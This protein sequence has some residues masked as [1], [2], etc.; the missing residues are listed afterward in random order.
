ML[1]RIKEA[2]WGTN[3][4]SWSH[5]FDREKKHDYLQEVSNHFH[6]LRDAIAKN[7]SSMIKF[8]DLSD[9]MIQVMADFYKNYFPKI[10]E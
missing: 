1:L 3:Q 6:E 5:K 8:V 10:N 7:L 2:E 9:K 4:S